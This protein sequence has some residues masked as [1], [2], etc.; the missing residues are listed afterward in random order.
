MQNSCPKM[1]RRLSRVS[2]SILAAIFNAAMLSYISI[3]PHYSAAYQ[4]LLLSYI[5]EAAAAAA[6]LEISFTTVIIIAVRSQLHCRY[7]LPCHLQIF[8]YCQLLVFSTIIQY[9]KRHQ[10]MTQIL[11]TRRSSSSSNSGNIIYN[12]DNHCCSLAATFQIYILL[13]HLQ[14][15]QLLS[16]TSIFDNYPV[17]K[18][19]LKHN[20][21]PLNDVVLKRGSKTV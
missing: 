6:A 7:I 18:E 3:P 10:N 5:L 15:F 16:V 13:C 21:G 9:L 11:Y 12:G 20:S 4:S 14:I 1:N 17:F 2:T 8:S 19:T